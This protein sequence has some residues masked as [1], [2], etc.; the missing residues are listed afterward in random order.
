MNFEKTIE[1]FKMEDEEKW[2][3]IGEQKL[4]GLIVA[5]DGPD[6]PDPHWDGADAS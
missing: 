2:L 1:R 6:E 5:P 4:L 3:E